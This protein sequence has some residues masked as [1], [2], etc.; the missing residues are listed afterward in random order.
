MPS[1]PANSSLVVDGAVGV[2]VRQSRCRRVV[3]VAEVDDRR[4]VEAPRRRRLSSPQ[5][6]SVPVSSAVT[7]ARSSAAGSGKVGSSGRRASA[8]GTARAPVAPS[9]SRVHPAVRVVGLRRCRH[10]TV[11]RV[12]RLLPAWSPWSPLLPCWCPVPDRTVPAEVALLAPGTHGDGGRRRQL[13]MARTTTGTSRGSVGGATGAGTRAPAR[14]PGGVR[15]RRVV[16]VERRDAPCRVSRV[17][18]RG[19][20][21]KTAAR[22][23]RVVDVVGRPDPVAVGVDAE[24]RP[25]E[26]GTA[27]ADARSQ[28]L[29]PST[30][31]ASVSATLAT[32][33]RPSSGTPRISGRDAVGARAARR[34]TARG[35]T[36]PADRRP[37]AS[38]EPARLRR[39]G[40][41]RG[42]A[43]VRRRARWGCRRRPGRAVAALERV[44]R[45]R[46]AR[47]RR[48]GTAGS[49]VVTIVSTGARRFATF[50]TGCGRHPRLAS[51]AHDAR[52][53]SASR[54]A[55][56]GS[57]GLRDHDASRVDPEASRGQNLRKLSRLLD[58]YPTLVKSPGRP[59]IRS[60]R[61]C[62]ARCGASGDGEAAGV[63]QLPHVGADLPRRVGQEHRSPLQRGGQLG[64][65]PVADAQQL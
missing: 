62:G 57:G 2:E 23:R 36:R 50:W 17:P 51:E 11:R 15:R 49:A 60:Q 47:L 20:Q 1:R 5:A 4:V 14:A 59:R 32:A 58:I 61:R 19:A 43:L 29:S 52:Q 37:A 16:A 64:V 40:R 27:S 3:G 65:L 28:R 39:P 25:V 46:P 31:P 22:A 48:V 54:S 9:P 63:E 10:G 35:R 56:V 8:H 12:S 13:P 44:A 38:G 41:D 21:G 26:A 18:G 30:R 33:L 7:G 6:A 34:R 45:D 24:R 53:R 55:R 42:L